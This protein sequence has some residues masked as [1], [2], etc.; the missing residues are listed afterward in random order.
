[1]KKIIFVLCLFAQFSCA[2]PTV[3]ENVLNYLSNSEKETLLKSYLLKDIKK[4]RD[5]TILEI[6]AAGKILT[7]LAPLIND[8]IISPEYQFNGGVSLLEY[9]VLMEYSEAV[10]F[11]LIEHKFPKHLIQRSLES[12]CSNGYSDIASQL[13]A[14]GADVNL[15]TRGS[16]WLCI[17]SAVRRLDEELLALLLQNDVNLAAKDKLGDTPSSILKDMRLKAKGMEETIRKK[18]SEQ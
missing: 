12:A 3:D 4:E 5:H 13:I 8:G 10:S 1:M 15:T 9:S 11:L 6:L 7:D 18:V 16:E 14:F 17:F 2:E